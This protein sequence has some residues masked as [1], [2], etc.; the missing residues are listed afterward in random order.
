MRLTP[1]AIIAIVA[2][3]VACPPSFLIL[4]TWLRRRRRRKHHDSTCIQF[5]NISIRMRIVSYQSAP[6]RLHAKV[7]IHYQRFQTA[8][9]RFLSLVSQTLRSV[10]HSKSLIVSQLTYLRFADY[11]GLSQH[12]R[13]S[14]PL[15][16]LAPQRYFTSHLP[17]SSSSSSPTYIRPSNIDFAHYN[18]HVYATPQ[19]TSTSPSPQR[20]APSLTIVREHGTF[21]LFNGLHISRFLFAALDLPSMPSASSIVTTTG[22]PLSLFPFLYPVS[23]VHSTPTSHFNLNFFF[24]FG[25]GL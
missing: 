20:H 1:E 18:N 10:P 19:R 12:H 21:L 3:V 22:T 17:Y 16:S 23:R 25:F 14:Y 5:I 9:P 15:S 7:F 8:E 24:F 6:L 4:W 11:Y 13:Q 2:V